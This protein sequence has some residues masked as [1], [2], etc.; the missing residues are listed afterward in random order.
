[1]TKQ[2]L[3]ILCG[4]F[5]ITTG[6][7]DSETSGS[8]SSTSPSPQKVQP[9]P[10]NLQVNRAVITDTPYPTLTP[11][12]DIPDSMSD[13]IPLEE[14]QAA[15]GNNYLRI[16]SDVWTNRDVLPEG[17]I[18]QISFVRSGGAGGS[19]G[20]SP[21]STEDISEPLILFRHTE[22]TIT[23]EINS[24]IDMCIEGTGDAETA[25]IDIYGPSEFSVEYQKRIYT[26]FDSSNPIIYINTTPKSGDPLGTYTV[27][28]SSKN[29]E[30]TAQY[31]VI[32]AESPSLWYEGYYAA[33]EMRMAL[34]EYRSLFLA[35]FSPSTDINFHLYKGVEVE[36]ISDRDVCGIECEKTNLEYLTSWRVSSDNRGEIILEFNSEDESANG[37]FLLI[38]SSP[39]ASICKLKYQ[40]IQ[41][42][43][44]WGS[45][46][47]D[48]VLRIMIGD[49]P[50]PRID[51]TENNLESFNCP[52]APVTRL[53]KDMLAFVSLDPP[54]SNRLRQYPGTAAK[55][56]GKIP[57]GQE[58]L[59]IGGPECLN[60]FVWWK[61]TVT[62]TNQVGWT[63]EGDNDNYWLIP[64]EVAP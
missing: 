59:I 31:E 63:V 26:L 4:I 20:C 34:G 14:I 61:V 13:E 2:L 40:F 39:N 32:G 55:E 35:G 57:P 24:P 27:H 10:T 54:M 48:M 51:N 12:T 46:T 49:E 42:Y 5:L 11:V 41:E 25:I 30:A 17:V 22:K 62:S 50:L 43:G 53:R 19:F 29:G 9:S 58:V 16:S 8:S 1:M 56:I 44:D 38:V 47:C 23:A 15:T 60:D 52:G 33:N 37:L 3:S 7:S 64:S 21:S 18:E 28:V 45:I 6:C 36:I